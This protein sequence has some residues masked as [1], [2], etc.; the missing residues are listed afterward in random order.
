[1]YLQARIT[2]IYGL[3][4][5]VIRGSMRVESSLIAAAAAYVSKESCS[6]VE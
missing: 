3:V 5:P 1:M 4:L 2:C 6:F